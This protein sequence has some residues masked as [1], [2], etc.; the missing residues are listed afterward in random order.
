MFVNEGCVRN[1]DK[2]KNQ[3]NMSSK[4]ILVCAST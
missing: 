3:V 2:K 4:L 1:N